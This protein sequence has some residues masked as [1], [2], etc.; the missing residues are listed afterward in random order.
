MK[1]SILILA[2]HPDDDVL[3]CGGTIAKL[4]QEG[5]KIHVAFLSDGVSSRGISQKKFKDELKSRRKASVAALKILG[6]DSIS[7]NDF[8]D[9]KMDSVP[10]IDIVQ[11][12]EVL[13]S[14]HVPSTVFTHNATD[15]NIDHQK[16]YEATVVACRPQPGHPVKTILSYEVASSTEW[17]LPRSCNGFLPNWYVDI[18]LT[19]NLKLS[20]LA[21]YKYEMRKWPHPRSLEAVEHL[22]RWRGATVGV[23]AAEAFMLGRYIA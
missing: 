6:V 11:A 18:S 10:L 9:N 5:K 12:I 15:V 2:A 20:S 17:Q 16:V 14:K 23:D 19:M 3:G 4:S 22:A 1:E 21:K 8:P 7:F 13:I